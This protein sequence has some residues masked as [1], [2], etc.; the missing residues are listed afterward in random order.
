MKRLQGKNWHLTNYP[1][2]RELTSASSKKPKSGKALPISIPLRY[3]IK[4][5]NNEK[6]VTCLE[7]PNISV[8]VETG[9]TIPSSAAHKSPPGTIYLDGVAQCEPFMDHE[10][11]I[12]NFDHHEG[13]LRPFT[14]S[15]CEQ[16]LVMILKGLDLRSRDWRILANEPDLDTI[17]AIWLILN[18]SRISNKDS[19]SL[20]LLFALV[21]LEGIIDS[22]GLEMTHLSAFPPELLR[23]TQRVI[24]YLRAKEVD[25][26]RK[27]I[28]EKTNFLEHT[29][30]TL[31]K[32]DKIIYKWDELVDFKELREL[33]RAKISDNRIV[34]VVEAELGIYELEPH[35]NRIYGERLGIVVLQKKPGIYTLR[36][37]DPFMPGDLNDV[38]Q[39]LNYIDP[40]VRCLKDGDRWG[41]SGDIGGSP[42]G[43][44]TE[45]SPERIGQICGEAFQSLNII[46]H[47]IRFFHA[48]MVVL[49]ITGV[50][51]FFNLFFS[52]H[53]WLNGK[54][55]PDLFIKTNFLFFIAL[56][57]FTILCLFFYSRGR[58][59]RFGIRVPR[60]KDFW[61]ALPIVILAAIANGIYLPG[62]NFSFLSSHQA[63][64]YV[65]LIFPLASELLF[66]SLVHGILAKG[67]HV[68]SCDDRWIFSYASVGSA[69]L[70]AGFM[71]YLL[72]FLNISQYDF[73]VRVMIESTFAAFAF[74]LAT[75]FVREKSQ[76]I[77]P[78]IFFHF[79]AVDVL[80]VSTLLI[81][82]D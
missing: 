78:P 43:F 38:Y 4:S 69:V 24:D 15:T 74:G 10:K 44:A 36:R 21:R 37:L 80:A 76:S 46:S 72:V 40:A 26:K 30:S 67:T 50:A 16:V 27:G 13:C 58:F 47:A 75:G 3:Q 52:S 20:E 28:W 6:F 31:H 64:V 5:S 42:R 73:Q 49:V 7:A 68:E 32:I 33:A 81:I 22:H 56:M 19:D 9:L 11:Q 82:P 53:F 45:L 29:A 23:R 2:K 71:A 59:W 61:I 77:I 70:Y 12:Y 14:L 1:Y 18:H 39:K 79:A 25:F 55:S 66:R 63:I 48:A 34:V 54:A 65:I 35:L 17:L 8:Q 62:K 51:T 57:F 60:G 41:G